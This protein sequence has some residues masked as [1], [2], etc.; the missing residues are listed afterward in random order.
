[1]VYF[2]FNSSSTS[3]NTLCAFILLKLIPLFFQNLEFSAK[4][5]VIRFLGEKIVDFGIAGDDFIDSVLERERLSSTCFLDVFAVPHSLHMN[6][7][8]TMVCILTSEKGIPWDEH[9]I[10]I[11]MMIAVHQEDR[12]K[13]MELYDGIVRVLENPQNIKQLVSARTPS[14]FINCLARENINR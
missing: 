5:N 2:Y 11:V 6:A 4:E 9:M 12:K 14:E 13:F 7:S 3:S 1:M 8:R 10:H